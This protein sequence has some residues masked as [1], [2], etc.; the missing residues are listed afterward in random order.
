MNSAAFLES[1]YFVLLKI[2]DMRKTL[3]LLVILSGLFMS[4]GKEKIDEHPAFVGYW[5][6]QDNL[7]RFYTID[8]APSGDVEYLREG[9]GFVTRSG[10]FK[11][12]NGGENVKLAGKKMAI[13]QYPMSD[14]TNYW[15]MQLDDIVLETWK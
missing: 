14:S 8:I 12:T 1:S 7:G 11:V 4:C 9:I 3:I 10:K 6:G 5:E 13:L 2:L 15:T